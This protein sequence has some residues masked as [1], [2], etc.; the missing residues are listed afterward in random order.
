MNGSTK[1]CILLFISN[2]ISKSINITKLFTYFTKFDTYSI[3]VNAKESNGN[4]HRKL[5]PL[6]SSHYWGW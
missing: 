3:F 6:Q 1:I 4:T 2:I 5:S